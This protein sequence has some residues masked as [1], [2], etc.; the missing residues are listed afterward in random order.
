V[1]ILRFVGVLSPLSLG[2]GRWMITVARLG[3]DD[4]R[5]RVSCTV[6]NRNVYSMLMLNDSQANWLAL[7]VG[8]NPASGPAAQLRRRLFS[9]RVLGRC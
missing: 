6:C 5:I 8:Q 9:W 4:S 3:Y 7:V 2:S 1:L